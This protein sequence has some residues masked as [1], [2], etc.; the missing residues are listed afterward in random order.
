RTL[1]ATLPLG[2]QP[3]S[4][5]VSPD[6]RYA[7][8]AIENERDE[9]VADGAPP[10]APAGFLA[11]VDL[12]GA[13]AVWTVRTVDRTR[14]PALYPEDPEPEHLDIHAANI[15]AVTLQE[16]N[17][18]VQVHLPTGRVIRHHP[19]GAVDLEQVDTDENDLIEPS[20]ALA[21]VLREPDGVTWL[22]P[23]SFATANEGDLDGGSRGFSIFNLAGKQL[24]DS[25]N[26]LEQA[27]IRAGHY[28][29]DRSE[30]KGNEPENV[31]F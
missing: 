2:G 18:I 17:H 25:G 9:D 16:N 21:G 24:H 27:V 31:A 7:A 8:I 12:V 26:S 19:A 4:V 15:A 28:P 3:D 29:E 13:P 11:I 22:T 1:I 6:G 20:A 30:N 23:L 14:L 5:A 10:Q